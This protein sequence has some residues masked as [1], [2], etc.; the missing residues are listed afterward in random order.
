VQAS[1]FRRSAILI[2]KDS[3]HCRLYEDVLSVYGFN[4]YTARS[5]MDGLMKVRETEQDLVIINTEVAEESFLEKLISKM[6]LERTSHLMPIIGLSVYNLE[7]KKNISKILDAFLTKPISID[8][9][10]ESVLACVES[11]GNGCE[12]INN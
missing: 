8:R 3:L 1:L 5:A 12:G 6:K 9:F 2:E 11:R 4:V 7:C 10:I